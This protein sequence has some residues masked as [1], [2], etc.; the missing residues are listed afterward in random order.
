MTEPRKD[1]ETWGVFADELRAHREGRSWSQAA[2]A[3]MTNYSESLIAQ[4]ETCHKP[5][6]M[7]L[8]E[9]LDEVFKTPGYRP[10]KDSYNGEASP[11]TF[12]RLGLKLRKVTFSAPFG[13]F[14]PYEAAADELY[15]FEHSLVP[16]P[17]QTERYAHAVLGTRPNTTADELDALVTSRNARGEILTRTSPAAPVCWFLIDEGV[18]HRPVAPAEDMREQLQHLDKIS[19]LPNVTIQV[20]PYAAGGHTGLLGACIVAETTGQA[21]IV[22]LEDMA[23]GRVSEDPA[24]VHKIKLRFKSLQSEALPKS[25]SRQLIRRVAE[26]WT[27]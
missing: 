1:A 2:L 9:K 24:T 26:T 6:S 3:K 18:L 22:Y 4:V 23:D 19:E 12:M 20:L 25:A 14:A 5:P 27:P 15:G 11:G 8:A 7:I 17:L 10:A 21:G 13:S 16:G